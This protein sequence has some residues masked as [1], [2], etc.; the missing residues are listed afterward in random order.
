M[1]RRFRTFFSF[2]DLFCQ[3]PNNPSGKLFLI[4]YHEVDIYIAPKKK[5][6]S[7]IIPLIKRLIK[8]LK[9]TKKVW[10]LRLFF[11]LLAA[12]ISFAQFFFFFLHFPSK[13]LYLFVNLSLSLAIFFGFLVH[14]QIIHCCCVSC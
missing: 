14:F 9:T 13:S 10:S 11:F 5:K 2:L 7:K 4:N 8:E 6:P 3:Q 12:L 1:W